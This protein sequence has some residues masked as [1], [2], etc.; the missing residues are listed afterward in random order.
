MVQKYKIS[1]LYA[2]SSQLELVSWRV[3]DPEQVS[4]D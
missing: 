4:I 2:I 3:H 1:Q